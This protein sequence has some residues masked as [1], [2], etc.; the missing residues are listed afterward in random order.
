ME[1]TKGSECVGHMEVNEAGEEL[2]NFL[3][4]NK[5]TIC[6]TWFYKRSIHTHTWQHPRSK[7]WHCID[8]ATVRQKDRRQCLDAE[9]KRGA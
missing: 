1:T 8:F 5:S 7:A 6:N 4:Q 3:L 9:V 2:L